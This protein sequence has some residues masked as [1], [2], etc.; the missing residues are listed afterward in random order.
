MLCDDSRLRGACALTVESRKQVNASPAVAEELLP[1][2]VRS[3]VATAIDPLFP[4]KEELPPR[5]NFAAAALP[6]ASEGAP[7]FERLY[8]RREE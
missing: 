7:H 6:K 5:A 3:L 1:G 2:L 8:A 4:P